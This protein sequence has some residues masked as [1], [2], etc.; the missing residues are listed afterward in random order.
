MPGKITH[1]E[2]QR[3][4]DDRDNADMRKVRADLEMIMAERPTGRG[5]DIFHDESNADANRKQRQAVL[6][7]IKQNGMDQGGKNAD[8]RQRL[9]Q[10]RRIP[11][12]ADYQ[13]LIDDKKNSNRQFDRRKRLAACLDGFLHGHHGPCFSS[14]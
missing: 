8:R 12:K 6:P 13:R 4:D 2:P 14:A 5:A 9:R 7:A 1:A 10:R 3:S 11:G